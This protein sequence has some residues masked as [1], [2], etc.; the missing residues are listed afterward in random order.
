MK[1]IP[2]ILSGPSGVGKSTL[3]RLITNMYNNIIQSISYTTRRHRKKEIDKRDYYFISDN[4]FNHMIIGKRF[5][6]WSIMY[7][8]KYGSDIIW[9]NK[10]LN[11][12]YHIIFDISIDGGIQIKKKM[13][14]LY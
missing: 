13:K 11:K 1:G 10:M 7:Q 3:S 14:I 6:E 4:N 2:I 12:G 5:L 8:Y 9:V